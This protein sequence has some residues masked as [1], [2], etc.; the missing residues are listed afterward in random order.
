MSHLTTS[1]ITATRSF[2]LILLVKFVLLSFTLTKIAARGPFD[3][4]NSGSFRHRQ[5]TPP[6]HPLGMFMHVTCRLSF[7]S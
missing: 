4:Q 5:L 3:T 6:S 7:S 2:N 1:T